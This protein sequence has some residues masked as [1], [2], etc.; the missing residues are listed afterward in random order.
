MFHGLSV[1]NG[2]EEL[3]HVVF[4]GPACDDLLEPD[5]QETK[6]SLQHDETEQTHQNLINGA[7]RGSGTR[8]ASGSSFRSVRLSSCSHE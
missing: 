7:C 4:S 6:L 2:S 3:V 1:A 5:E 8:T